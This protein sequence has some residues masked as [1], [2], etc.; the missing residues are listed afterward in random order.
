MRR[1]SALSFAAMRAMHI[2]TRNSKVMTVR[3]SNLADFY[4][5]NHHLRHLSSGRVLGEL[6]DI[7]RPIDERLGYASQPMRDAVKNERSERPFKL[8]TDGGSRGNPGVSGAGWV[9]K[10]P[11]GKKVVECYVHLG[12]KT[13]NYAEYAAAVMGMETAQTLGIKQLILHLDSEL[14]VRQFKGEYG[15]KD[16]TL[17]QLHGA[18]STSAEKFDSIRVQHVFRN[19]NK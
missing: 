19:A 15:V 1:C 8:W 14:V 5:C 12:I 10:S 2:A 17:K 18:M 11:S 3:S 4:T 6:V 9:I 16:A 13:N 7:Y